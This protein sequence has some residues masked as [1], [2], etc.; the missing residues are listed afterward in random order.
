MYSLENFV[1]AFKII[2]CV[3][4]FV[5]LFALLSPASSHSWYDPGCCSGNDCAVVTKMT[6]HQNNTGWWMTNKF[7]KVFVPDSFEKKISKDG[8]YHVC[9]MALPKGDNVLYCVYVPSFT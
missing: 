3:V 5:L 2:S 6:R 4:F 8:E 1:F 7:G 9:F